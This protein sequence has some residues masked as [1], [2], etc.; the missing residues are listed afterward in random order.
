MPKCCSIAGS[1]HHPPRACSSAA[2]TTAAP[3]PTTRPPPPRT[4]MTATA[5]TTRR[6]DRPARG[7]DPRTGSSRCRRCGTGTAASSLGSGVASGGRGHAAAA[8]SEFGY[9]PMSYALNFGDHRSP[10]SDEEFPARNFLARLPE[11]R[12]WLLPGKLPREVVACS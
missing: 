3:P 1:N 5:N 9:D 10:D 4:A 2:S 8:A 12:D 7:S 6:L 11:S